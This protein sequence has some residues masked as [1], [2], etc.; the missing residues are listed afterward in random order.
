[1]YTL[2]TF[3]DGNGDGVKKRGMVYARRHF[4][5][6]GVEMVVTVVTGDGAG[7]GKYFM[8]NVGRG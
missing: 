4:C 8:G 5:E 3:R 1:M 7:T 6:D 2:P